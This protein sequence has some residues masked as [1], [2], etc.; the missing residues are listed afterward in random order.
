MDVPV[1]SAADKSD[2]YELSL[3]CARSFCTIAT[4][5]QHRLAKLSPMTTNEINALDAEVLDWYHCLPS[6]FTQLENCPANFV[7]S[8]DIMR[9]RYY[10]LRLLL[11]RPVLLRYATAKF[12]INHALTPVE[13][14]SIQKCRTIACEA[15]DRVAAARNSVNRLRAW[16]SVWYLYQS[17]MV[18]LLSILVDGDHAQSPQWQASVKRAIHF[19]EFADPLTASAGRSRKVVRSLLDAC[20]GV[21][22]GVNTASTSSNVQQQQ[23]GRLAVPNPSTWTEL[24]LDVFTEQVADWDMSYWPA[25]LG[26][27]MNWNTAPGI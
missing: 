18:L 27:G 7:T 23:D 1:A 26:D 25:E 14:E 11:H 2:L 5:V 19:F 16:S 22:C 15:I 24:G 8:Q 12:N 10:N 9:N 4:K 17:S 21:P 6:G 20:T 13:Y 3:D